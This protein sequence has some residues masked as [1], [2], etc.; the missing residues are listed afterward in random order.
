M[1]VNGYAYQPSLLSGYTSP[2]R[3]APQTSTSSNGT[4]ITPQQQREIDRL[5]A[6]DQEV[7]THEQAHLSAAGDIA[8]SGANFSYVTGPDGQRYASGGEVGIDT[9]AVDGDPEATIR[10]AASIRRAALAPAQ[11][12]A[13]DFSVASKAD[14][15]ANKARAELLKYQLTPDNRAKPLHL[16]V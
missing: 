1:Q 8:V 11:P 13:Q 14:A 5:K 2:A 3:P 9:S 7:R 15:M 6:Q 10:K 4:P 16:V 12:S